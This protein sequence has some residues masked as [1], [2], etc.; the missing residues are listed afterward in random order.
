MIRANCGV[1]PARPLSYRKAEV[2]LRDAVDWLADIGLTKPPDH[3]T[4]W[5]AFGA[6]C[7]L[8]R[9]NSMLD[10]QAQLFRQAHR[11]KLRDKPLALDSTCYEPHHRSRHYDWRCRKL[12]LGPGAKFGRKTAVSVNAR[13]ARQH[14]RMP[15]LATAAA[16]SCHL[17][18]AA[19]GHIGSGSD[20]PDFVPL[21]RQACRRAPVR[22]AVADGGFDS[23]AN[24]VVARTDLHVRSI[25]PADA[26]RPSAKLP[27]GR[28][29]RHMRR[30]FAR[31]ADKR[32]Y[33][34]RAQA[35][36]LQSMLK[37]NLGDELRSR[38]KDRRKQEM[39]FRTVVH[40]IT[41]TAALETG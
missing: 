7:T 40:N 10:L 17:V 18:L 33:G 4:L 8:R 19:R 31:A 1:V 30:R 26:G 25:I 27:A 38:R 21:L 12:G 37:R 28:W 41:L 29:R 14:R 15:K 22:S 13:R 16:A 34:Q 9:L 5:R 20:A 6:L 36:T 39:V 23:E 35:E 24:H 3:N 11:L 32:R 2:F